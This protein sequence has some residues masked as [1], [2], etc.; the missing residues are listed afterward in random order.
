MNGSDGSIGG[1]DSISVDKSELKTRGMVKLVISYP[2]PTEASGYYSCRTYEKVSDTNSKITKH[3]IEIV[4]APS[5][6]NY[7]RLIPIR[8][9]LI[10]FRCE[11][12][13]ITVFLYR[14]SEC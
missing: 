9:Y 2:L 10:V 6:L 12:N 8:Y 4:A 13:Q 3:T 14:R 11:S 7:E 1:S 5:R